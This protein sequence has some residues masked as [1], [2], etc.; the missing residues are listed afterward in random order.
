MPQNCRIFVYGASGHGKVVADILIARGVT[1]AGF[2][3]DYAKLG[4]HEVLGLKVLGNS[5][6]LAEQAKSGSVAVALGIGDNFERQRV[7]NSCIGWHIQLLTAIHPFAVVAASARVSSGVVVMASSVINPDAQIGTGA[8]VN[9]GA[10]IEHDCQVGDFAHLS[11]NAAMGGCA[12]LGSLSW[13][14]MGASI[15]HGVNVGSNT[16]VGAGAVVVRDLPDD[17]VAVGV[18][19]SIRRHLRDKIG[20]MML[21]T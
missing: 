10:I 4:S 8:I 16:I 9:T 21:K 3:D 2:I 17:V 18:P 1:V 7:A 12:Q 19:A 20:S 14:G 11:P 13:L 5:G 6:W 15:I